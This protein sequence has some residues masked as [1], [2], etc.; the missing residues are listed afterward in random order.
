[1]TTPDEL[2]LVLPD[3][4]GQIGAVPPAVDVDPAATGDPFGVDIA[5][6]RPLLPPVIN[7]AVVITRF[8][9]RHAYDAD[10]VAQF[11][12]R[13]R[14][15]E[16]PMSWGEF[17]HGPSARELTLLRERIGGGTELRHPVAVYA[18]VT[19]IERDRHQSPVLRFADG[20]GFTVRVRSDHPSLLAP[21]SVGDFVL[22]VGTWKVWVPSRGRPEPQMFAEKHWQLAH[23]TY[24]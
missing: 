21:L 24:D 10:V 12:V 4:L 19:A 16:T 11:K 17:C 1:M 7:S 2:H 23:W 9:Q 20:A 3:D 5:T 13:R 15:E 18:R 14:G 6:V 22:A 8:L